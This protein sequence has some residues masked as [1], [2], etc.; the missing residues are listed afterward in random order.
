MSNDP[1]PVDVLA[2]LLRLRKE[3]DA[4]VAKL[5]EAE[6]DQDECCFLWQREVDAHVSTEIRLMK[7]EEERDAARARLATAEAL[8]RD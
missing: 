2:E 7:V 5:T 4:A 1:T 6:R 3:R 8:L